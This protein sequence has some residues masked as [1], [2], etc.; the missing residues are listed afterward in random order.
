MP[1]R[2]HC[3]TG[4]TLIELIVV[5]AI[6]AVLLGMLLGAVQ[7]TRETANRV[8]CA[9]NLR[10]L[11]IAI[12]SYHSE[13]G[14][15][16]PYA[17]SGRTEIPG[18]WL[19]FLLPYFGQQEIYNEIR[20][21]YQPKPG[22]EVEVYAMGAAALPGVNFP[23]VLCPSDPSV[24]RDGTGNYLANWFTFAKGEKGKAQTGFYLPPY[25]FSDIT[26]GLSNVVLFAEGYQVCDTLPR[27]ALYPVHYHNFGVTQ[28]GL[29]SDDP[30]YL[31]EDY[32][33]FQVR[34]RSCDKLRSQTPHAAMQVTMGDGSV[35]PVSAILPTTWKQILKPN[36]GLPQG[37]DW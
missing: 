33:M 17:S 26:D 12:H 7:A 14:K 8:H 19:L 22:A 13:R 35:R 2:T 11:G 5:M 34:P 29:P 24:S 6:V 27:W 10:Q 15:M 4:F 28:D 23:S 36:D 16:P 18:G 37:T 3:R 32:T 31:P 25:R 20:A 30:A 9:N 1:R 21:H